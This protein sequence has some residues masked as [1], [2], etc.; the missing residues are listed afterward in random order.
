MSHIDAAAFIVLKPEFANVDSALIEVELEFAH[1][2]VCENTWGKLFDRA[3]CLMVAHLLTLSPTTR[4]DTE[5]GDDGAGFVANSETVGDTS[6]SYDSTQIAQFAG[7]NA[8]PI[9]K[10]LAMTSYGRQ[11]HALRKRLGLTP[12]TTSSL[13]NI[14][15]HR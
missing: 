14:P 8:G 13:K 1:L 3:Y 4:P 15:R 7:Q 10:E 11:Y 9:A 5:E 12:R 6:V 2:L